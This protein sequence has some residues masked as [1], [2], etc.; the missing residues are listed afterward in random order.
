M[1]LSQP[2]EI[3]DH[4]TT[5]RLILGD[6]RSLAYLPD[7]SIHLAVTSPPYWTLKRYNEVPGQLGHVAEY[8]RFL[9]ELN[10]VWRE[11]YRLL[12]PGGR[13]VC[14]VGD[15]CLSRR[16][17][18]R[19]VVVPLH[20]DIAVN[21]RKIGFDNLNPIIWHKIANANYEVENG[22]KFL[23][24]PYEPNAIIKNDIE[25][26]LM[27]RKPGGYRKPTEEQRR[28]SM[29]GKEEYGAWFQQFWNITGASTRN[30]PAPFPLELAYRLVRMFSFWGDTVLDP[31]SGT[32]TTILAAERASRN[33]IGI[34]IDKDYCRM[35]LK[36]FH[37]EGSSL[38]SGRR[39]VFQR[40]EDHGGPPQLS[41]DPSI[42]EVKPRKRV[43]KPL[44]KK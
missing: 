9:E 10:K 40:A 26:I 30:H 24:K 1:T 36:R 12:V 19:H 5:H 8:E 39:L 13:L 22:T 33:S 34:D 38:F 6:A 20:A 2:C 35:A 31:F 21:C 3:P 25:F 27:Q 23:G 7:E 17:F 44:P 29:I 37:T 4:P 15:V 41:E 28:L 43:I 32:G 18:G 14:V 11:V 42:Y 16:E